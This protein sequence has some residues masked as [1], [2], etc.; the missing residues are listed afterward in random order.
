MRNV[1]CPRYITGVF[2]HLMI[3]Q[4]KLTLSEKNQI[5]LTGRKK[6]FIISELLPKCLCLCL[7]HML[8]AVCFMITY[9]CLL[10]YYPS[11]DSPASTSLSFFPF[12]SCI[13]CLPSDLLHSVLHHSL[14]LF[15]LLLSPVFFTASVCGIDVFL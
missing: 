2:Y 7:V 4:N 6:L 5:L 13:S 1:L 3:L 10:I 9:F 14:L 8:S 15:P 12:P 11:F